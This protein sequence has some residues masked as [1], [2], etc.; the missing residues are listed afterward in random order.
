MKKE[1]VLRKWANFQQTN[2]WSILRGQPT[3]LMLWMAYEVIIAFG[4]NG[5]K[6]MVQVEGMACNTFRLN[7]SKQKKKFIRAWTWTSCLIFCSLITVKELNEPSHFKVFSRCKQ[8]VCSLLFLTRH[9]SD[10]HFRLAHGHM[11]WH[12]SVQCKTWKHR[13]TIRN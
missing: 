5:N 7:I 4:A 10:G 1:K 9:L 11:N 13:Q 3:V 8:K 12:I 2:I 6:F